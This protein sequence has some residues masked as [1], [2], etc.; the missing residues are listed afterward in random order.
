MSEDRSQARLRAKNV[1]I[2]DSFE[3]AGVN[4]VPARVDFDVWWNANGPGQALGDGEAV[5]DTNPAAFRGRFRPARS[6][7]RFS[8]SEL[9][10]RFRSNPGASSD[11]GYAEIGTEKNGSF[12]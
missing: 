8:G 4:V 7:G 6:T 12:L 10:F 3:F 9:G 2:L 11:E 5:P 1:P